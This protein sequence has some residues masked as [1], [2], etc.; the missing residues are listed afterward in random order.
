MYA[1][2]ILKLLLRLLLDGPDIWARLAPNTRIPRPGGRQAARADGPV[3]TPAPDGGE[4]RWRQEVVGAP[5]KE[6]ALGSLT[7]PIDEEIAQG[8]KPWAAR[9]EVDIFLILFFIARSGIGI[10]TGRGRPVASRASEPAIQG[11]GAYTADDLSRLTGVLDAGI[12]GQPVQFHVLFVVFKPG[13]RCQEVSQGI[14]VNV[15]KQRTVLLLPPRLARFGNLDPDLGWGKGIPA[16]SHLPISWDAEWE[17]HPG[18][19]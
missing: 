12:K 6:W 5:I 3:V 15:I 8:C 9:R 16:G 4:R 18:Y 17:R 14:V 19:I 13:C 1:V 11:G 2:L 10:E 7:Q